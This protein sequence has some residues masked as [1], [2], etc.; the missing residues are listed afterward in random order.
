MLSSKNCGAATYSPPISTRRKRSS[1]SS[2]SGR[3]ASGSS[4]VPLANC[5]MV[6][7]LVSARPS[8]Q[9]PSDANSAVSASSPTTATSVLT[10]PAF[11]STL[12]CREAGSSGIDRDRNHFLRSHP[13]ELRRRVGGYVPARRPR[14]HAAPSAD[15]SRRPLGVVLPAAP[16]RLVARYPRA[17]RPPGLEPVNEEK[18]A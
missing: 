16:A 18:Q 3:L 17:P 1:S 10:V 6:A 12:E 4:S 13:R 7:R 2:V 9:N 8:C 5:A 14:R 11:A 15:D